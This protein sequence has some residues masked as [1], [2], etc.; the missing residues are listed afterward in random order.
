[1]NVC[2]SCL[3]SP[4]TERKEEREEEGKEEVEAGTNTHTKKPHK[5]TLKNMQT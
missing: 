4:N 3:L 1:M 2:G 5:R